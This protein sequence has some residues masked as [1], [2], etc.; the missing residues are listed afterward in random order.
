MY[1]N[2]IDYILQKSPDVLL[3]TAYNFS[4]KYRNVDVF[5][6]FYLTDYTF[7]IEPVQMDVTEEKE[8]SAMD[9]S[10]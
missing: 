2:S 7:Y 9:Q 4:Q 6:E 10:D 1:K 5:R 8:N 3:I